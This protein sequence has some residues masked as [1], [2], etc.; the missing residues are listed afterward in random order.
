MISHI[1]LD[2]IADIPGVLGLAFHVDYWDYIGWKDPFATSVSTKPSL[3]EP[4]AGV[5]LAGLS[6]DE[7][8]A[9]VEAIRALG[10][11]PR[12][13]RDGR[14]TTGSGERGRDPVHP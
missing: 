13:R 8:Q 2:Q 3:A 12:R 1:V 7:L 14:R 10:S 11:E 5:S 6:F 4:G 9:T